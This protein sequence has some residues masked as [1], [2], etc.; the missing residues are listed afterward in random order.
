MKAG[1][2]E[3]DREKLF[4]IIG[5]LGSISLLAIAVIRP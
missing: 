3:M 4:V 1:I 5:F 2:V